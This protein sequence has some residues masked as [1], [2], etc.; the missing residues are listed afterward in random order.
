MRLLSGAAAGLGPLT[1][2]LPPSHGLGKILSQLA[3]RAGIATYRVD[4]Q[5]GELYRACHRKAR[6]ASLR[7][8]P[9][10]VVADSTF[11]VWIVHSDSRSLSQCPSQFFSASATARRLRGVS[12]DRRR[13]RK[14][15]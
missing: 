1:R 15:A 9:T 6:I 8:S 4:G 5:G 14:L 3:T 11:D 13:P 10:H 2:K 12:G 7:L